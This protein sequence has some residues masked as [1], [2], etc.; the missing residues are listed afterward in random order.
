MSPLGHCKSPTTNLSS[1]CRLRPT[2]YGA[3][4]Y[5]PAW[6]VLSCLTN[7]DY[8]IHNQMSRP[9]IWTW[10]PSTPWRSLSKISRVVLLSSPTTSVRFTMRLI[11]IAVAEFPFPSHSRSYLPS[12]RGLVGSQGQDHQESNETRYLDRRLQAEAREAQSA[13]SYHHS[14]ITADHF[15]PSGE[16][17]L[18]KA[19][20]S[21][22]SATKGKT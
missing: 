13:Y 5:S 2:C 15:T 18:E 3:S 17:A 22:K 19:K 14:A 20:L 12:S 6:C 9:I 11:F 16:A 8:I 10:N 21:S 7:Y 4:T 1:Q